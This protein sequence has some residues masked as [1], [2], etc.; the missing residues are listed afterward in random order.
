M[1][2]LAP[3][4]IE[5][6]QLHAGIAVADLRAAIDF[7]V[8]KLG[9]TEAFNWG[10]PVTFAGINLGHAQIFL[11]QGTPTPNPDPGTE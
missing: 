8:S 4:S 7:Y 3:P 10:T 6:D 1:T 11:Q 2:N 5:C 9:F